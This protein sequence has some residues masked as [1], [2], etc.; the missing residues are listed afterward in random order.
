VAGPCNGNNEFLGYIKG[1]EFLDYECLLA[2]EGGIC[3]TE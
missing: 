3:S 2:P 1:G